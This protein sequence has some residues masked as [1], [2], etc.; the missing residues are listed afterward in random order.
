[1][2]LHHF[3]NLTW[4]AD[5]SQISHQPG[6]LLNLFDHTVMTKVLHYFPR[7]ASHCTQA[8]ISSIDSLWPSLTVQQSITLQYLACWQGREGGSWQAWTW[9][10]R[11]AG[12]PWKAP[13]N[14]LKEREKERAQAAHHSAGSLD[15]NPKVHAGHMHKKEPFLLVSECT[16]INVSVRL[17]PPFQLD[18]C[19]G[20]RRCCFDTVA[21]IFQLN[22]RAHHECQI[23]QLWLPR[24]Y[25]QQHRQQS[26]YIPTYHDVWT[27]CFM[28]KLWM[29]FKKPYYKFRWIIT[30][31][32]Q[33]KSHSL[34][35]I[36]RRIKPPGHFQ[37]KAASHLSFTWQLWVYLLSHVLWEV[38]R[39][40]PPDVHEYSGVW[41]GDLVDE[42]RARVGQHQ[43]SMVGFKLGTVLERSTVI[44]VR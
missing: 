5:K 2:H 13:L 32:P 7:H 40:L 31:L 20:Y 4:N 25:T 17:T 12:P 15:E 8:E 11:S 37:N 24:P 14:A 27:H 34:L 6:K 10:D 28:K 18:L 3:L 33:A 21:L 29:T 38:A 41:G 44:K 42:H 1:M 23:P 16:F 19:Q 26:G 30:L 43:L 9:V 22:S 36:R 35:A 39:H